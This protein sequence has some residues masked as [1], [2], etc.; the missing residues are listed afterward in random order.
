MRTRWLVAGV[1][2]A[3]ACSGPVSRSLVPDEA[4][5]RFAP[6]PEEPVDVA[7]VLEPFLRE[8]CLR[9]HSG[10]DP[11]GGVAFGA[12]AA[13]L[14]EDRELWAEVLERAREGD[15]PP[16]EEPQPSAVARQAFVRGLERALG[17]VAGDPGRV[18]IRRLNRAEYDAAVQDLLG[19]G[20]S[21]AR[22]FPRDE[23]GHGFDT[24][25]DALSI[26]P[27]LL[28]K[29][30]AAAEDLAAEALVD[31]KPLIQRVTGEALSG[32]GTP[33]RG[34]RAFASV[35]RA[36]FNALVAVGGRYRIL[37]EAF[38]DQ[39]GPDPAR[40][41]VIV[42]GQR[43]GV[44]ET[45]GEGREATRD[46]GLE[47]ALEP[48]EHRIEAGFPNDYYRPQ[49]PDPQQR[50]RNLFVVSLSVAGPSEPPR[51]TPFMAR[52]QRALAEA[53]TQAQ[54]TRDALGPLMRRAF[55]RP[56][57][58]GEL[59]RYAALADAA[60]EEGLE[61][62]PALGRA[63]TA[64]LVS[65]H[66]LF[67]PELDARPDSSEVRD[68]TG[69]ELASR[70]SFFL[71][72]SL[73][74]EAAL[75]SAEAGP[76]RGEA[77]VREAR[78]LLADPRADRFVSAFAGQWLGLR[79]LEDV[80]PDPETFPSFDDGLRQSMRAESELV[81]TALL[82]ENRSVLE[83]LNGRFTF[84][85]ERLA[86]HYGIPG[87][88]GA[89]FRRVRLPAE[90]RGVLTHASV[91]TVTSNP[92][93][94]SPVQRG[95]WILEQLLDDPPPP[96]PP[97]AGDLPDDPGA[98]AERS[99]VE[100]LEAHQ[101]RADCRSC[102]AKLD[103]LGIALERFDGVGAFRTRDGRHA[104]EARGTLPDGTALEG[105]EGLSAALTREP[106]RFVRAFVKQLFVYG[107]GR[108]PQPADAA[109]LDAVVAATAP[110]YRF[111]DILEEL[112][113]LPAFTQRRGPGR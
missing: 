60:R 10:E 109:A 63:L 57:A 26:S 35:G 80:D 76:L 56:L 104:I 55:R 65:P 85:D 98:R 32:G 49:D 67:R 30:L 23:S 71:W 43:V 40:I 34:L 107:L 53:P 14:R 82:R 29:Y 19:V 20:L 90:R 73:P 83:L 87:I 24:V 78:R 112:V 44:L 74:D 110:E 79:R 94:T 95:K 89:R 105:A 69:Y 88:E 81:L 77:L 1:L 59:E 102:H 93:R 38:A 17:V 36:G 96:P 18:T 42:D 33:R 106:R 75:S 64:V 48:G 27:L 51:P 6:P 41:E 58:A 45:E 3:V 61:F 9:C 86:K 66:F 28:E 2:G 15:M 25:G 47:V 22:A 97:G 16:A 12:L 101:S 37:V 68:L 70:L 103:P 21:P 91:L 39:A 52:L 84:V 50:D 7:L 72:C 111:A 31:P 100:R 113:Q 92:S 11:E 46:Y 8:H 54:A 13:G 62:F 99:G 4:L 5:R 108:A